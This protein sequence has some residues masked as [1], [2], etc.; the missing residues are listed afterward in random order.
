[1][2]LNVNEVEEMEVEEK[3]IGREPEVGKA[4]I[5]CWS[6]ET[7]ILADAISPVSQQRTLF[8]SKSH[9]SGASRHLLQYH[10]DLVYGPSLCEPSDPY[11]GGILQA[12]P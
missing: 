10:L 11:S 6:V 4:S 2:V 12:M 1:M 7:C 8:S 9:R 3:G 5:T